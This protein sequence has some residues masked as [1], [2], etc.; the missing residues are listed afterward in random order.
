LDV[1]VLTVDE[2]HAS[3][4]Q[5]DESLLKEVSPKIHVHRT[6]SFEPIN[7]YAKLVGKK[8]VPTAGFANVDEQ[9]LSQK[10]ASSIRSHLFIPDPRKGWNRYAYR[11]A[12]EIIE[13]QDIDVVITTSP[14]HSTQ[15]I[16]MKLKSRYGIKWI[17]DLRDP[18]TDIYYYKSLGHSPISRAFDKKLEKAVLSTAD[19]IL[20]VSDS[21]IDLFLEKSPTLRREGFT[22]IPNGYDEDDFSSI[23][24]VKSTGELLITYTGT[25]SGIY[26]PETLFQSLRS[27]L[28][29][30]P[31]IH[32]RLQ[33]V[34]HIAE[35]IME[36]IKS[37][38][39][40]VDYLGMVPHDKVVIYQQSADIL[41][42]VIPAIENAKG[43]LTGKIFEY[44]A[45]RNQI[46]CLGPEDGDAAAILERTKLGK[47]FSRNHSDQLTEH[48]KLL[49]RNW[50]KG[51]SPLPNE[52]EILTF[53]RRRQAQVIVDLIQEG[54]T[55]N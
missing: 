34:G 16:G 45:T 2:R 35:D 41:L 11:R 54:Q 1:H 15:L 3:Y 47:T 32:A 21:L 13:E 31:G 26:R 37:L 7:L 9:K 8:N 55:G 43:I 27:A 52:E 50:Q 28:D 19:H 22:L 30:T 5:M 40:S 18:W 20:T 44:L 49:F 39:L 51:V 4:M 24:E 29:A 33:I 53:S 46:V 25:M 14:P 36:Q 42:L 12:C 6:R 48:F 17:C 38:D 23:E 10:I